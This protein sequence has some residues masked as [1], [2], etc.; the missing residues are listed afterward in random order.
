[1]TFIYN[2]NIKTL[3]KKCIKKNK[4]YIY[5]AGFN[6]DK[7]LKSKERINEELSDIRKLVKAKV[8]IIL[9][10]H[11][12][13]YNNKNTIHLNFLKSYLEKKLKTKILYIK[14]IKY[15][16]S[17]KLIYHINPGEILFLPNSRFF[18]G[19][20]K[21]SKK[22]GKKF[23]SLGDII[24]VGGF[25]K[26]HRTNASNNSL[27]NYKP[28]IM[29]KGIIREIKKIHKWKNP[30]KNSICILG[31]VKKEKITIGLNFLSKFYDFILPG[32]IVLNTV[33]YVLGKKVGTSILGS[34]KERKIVKKVINKYENKILIPDKV[35]V[36]QKANEKKNR[37]INVNEIEK[38]EIIVGY[39]LNNKMKKIFQ[40]CIISKSNILLAGTPSFYKY[41][42]KEPSLSIIRYMKKNKSNSLLLGGDSVSELNFNGPKSSGGGSALYYLSNNILPVITGL[43]KNQKK[44]NVF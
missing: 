30:K 44:F 12:G 26:A 41:N 23:A 1:M 31:G 16:F 38:N 25:S 19:E 2:N 22:L 39:K 4:V 42:F 5:S 6:I 43:C 33:L 21:N 10:S 14:N 17:R 15:I 24:I 11:Q 20:E 7:S 35:I 13:S 36:M 29:S 37:I 32:G 40:K 9:L 27:L 28:A 34:K 18:E 3:S 8:K